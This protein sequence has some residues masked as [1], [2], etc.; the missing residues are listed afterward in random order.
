M[1]SPYEKIDNNLLAKDFAHDGYPVPNQLR[2]DP[3]DLP[4]TGDKVDFVQG[5]ASVA[6]AGSPSLRNGMGIHVYAA[7]TDMV[8]KA[9][10]N[11]D[12]DLLIGTIWLR[13]LSGGKK[14]LKCCLLPVPQLGALDIQTEFGFL[15]VLPNQIA[16]IQRGIVFSVKLPDGPSRGYIC[17][18]FNGH[19]ELPDLGPIGIPDILYF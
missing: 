13:C 3:F 18:V 15:E 4:A 12:G 19:F 8:D 6:G 10:Y 9:F 11:A 16:V 5:L 7:N 1:H 17:E 14:K 2:W